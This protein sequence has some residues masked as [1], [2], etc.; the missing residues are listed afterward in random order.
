[1]LS[2]NQGPFGTGLKSFPTQS[3]KCLATQGSLVNHTYYSH[4]VSLNGPS[5][6]CHNAHSDLSKCPQWQFYDAGLAENNDTIKRINHTFSTWPEVVISDK[7]ITSKTF[8]ATKEWK[9][10]KLTQIVLDILGYIPGNIQ[11]WT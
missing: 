6:T 11:N 8:S 10:V 4:G 1:M 2:P 9:N 3:N 5:S 7:N